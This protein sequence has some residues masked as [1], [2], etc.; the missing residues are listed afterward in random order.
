MAGVAPGKSSLHSSF[1][2]ELGTALESRQGNRALIRIEGGF[3]RS[4]WSCGRKP[5][6]PSTCDSHL[7]ELLRFLWEVRNT[8]EL[9]RVS[10]DS[11][12]VGTMEAASSRVEVGT[13][14]SSP[15]LTWVLGCVFHFKQGVRSRHVWRHGTLLS[16][17]VVKGASGSRRVEFWPWTL[18]HLATWASV[19]P[20]CCELIHG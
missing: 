18:F 3:S 5:W 11:I 2:G 8:V 12:E 10:Q 17:R 6:F 13:S 14:C 1:E 16:S 19:L 4:F 7:R 15:V 20:S 9:R